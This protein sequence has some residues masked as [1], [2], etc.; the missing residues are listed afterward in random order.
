MHARALSVVWGHVHN[1]QDKCV[2]MYGTSSMCLQVRKLQTLAQIWSEHG[3]LWSQNSIYGLLQQ[4]AQDLH[5]NDQISRCLPTSQLFG[6]TK[7]EPWIGVASKFNLAEK[8]WKIGTR[9]PIDAWFPI[10]A[11]HGTGWRN[12]SPVH[13]T[14]NTVH[15]IQN[16]Q[17]TVPHSCLRGHRIHSE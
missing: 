1:M 12:R 16:I 8:D 17:K 2:S 4:A 13:I 14:D 15:H 9:S 10:N 5:R 6:G 7:R 3:D 11:R